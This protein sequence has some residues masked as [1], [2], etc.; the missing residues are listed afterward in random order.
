MD[1]GPTYRDTSLA[2]FVT[3]CFAALLAKVERHLRFGGIHDVHELKT[4]SHAE[5]KVGG[6]SE[7]I[8]RSLEGTDSAENA[9]NGSGLAIAEKRLRPQNEYRAGGLSA[10]GAPR[11]S[12]GDAGPWDRNRTR[13]A[14]A[15]R[16]GARV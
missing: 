3:P 14:E 11:L 9:L 4:G 1:H 2:Q 12:Q 7:N 6:K 10:A 16:V 15:G 8:A 13:L 5:G